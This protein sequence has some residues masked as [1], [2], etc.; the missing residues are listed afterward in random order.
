MPLLLRV[1]P[2][3][4]CAT[5]AVMAGH[6]QLGSFLKQRRG[7]VSPDSVGLGAGKLHH[8]SR[9]RVPG[10][11]REEVAQLA[12]ISVEYYQRL[13]QGRA[14]HPSEEVLGAIADALRLDR[15][16][17]GHLRDLAHPVRRPP[18]PMMP[19]E[20]A[21]PQLQRMLDLI[22]RLPALIV[23]DRFDVLA[24]NRLIVR[25]FEAT[26]EAVSAQGNLAWSLFLNP[27]AR[28]LY[29]DWRDVA[30]ATVAQLRLVTGRYPHDAASAALVAEL[31]ARSGDFAEL[32]A[33]GD[34]ELRT[35]GTKSFRHPTVGVL[36]LYYENLD[37]PG[38]L[39]QRLVTFSPDPGTPTATA[40][41]QLA[42]E[43][44]R[45]VGVSP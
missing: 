28:D 43:S 22:D 13:E 40:L 12:G 8:A 21:R 44:S 33:T 11:R 20:A 41:Q 10:L 2:G 4:P 7:R 27:A 42:A 35:H 3:P 6:D 25:L 19:S 26:P 37:L 39:R 17:R 9:R 1:L 18:A 34:V 24:T 5:L 32:W 14:K 30:A 45:S 16:E 36:T 23:N 31:T 29:V 15:V 38:D